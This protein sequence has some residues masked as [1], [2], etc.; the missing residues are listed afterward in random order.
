MIA[1]AAIRKLMNS[2][3]E[4]QYDSLLVDNYGLSC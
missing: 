2:T 1:A 4:Y 3:V